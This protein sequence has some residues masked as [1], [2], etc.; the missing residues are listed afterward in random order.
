MSVFEG[1]KASKTINGSVILEDLT[2]TIS[3]GERVAI[4]GENGSGKSTLLKLIAGIYENTSGEVK[5]AHLEKGYVPEHFPETIKL[6]LQE[7]LMLVGKMSGKSKEELTS[8]ISEYAKLFNVTEFLHTPL[9][10]CSKGTKQKAGIIQA[11]L[12]EPDVLLMDEPLTGLDD[13]AQTELLTQLQSLQKNQ[14]VIFTAHESYLIDAFAERVL[15]IKSGRLVYD[16]TKLNQE[17]VRIIKATVPTRE[18]ISGIQ[19]MSKKWHGESLVE[20]TVSANESDR[21]L[22]LLLKQG[23]SIIEVSEKR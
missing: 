20:L 14:T 22:T 9:K 15:Q 2:L 3:Q 12:K 8:E 11:L 7:Y 4:T 1:N 19:A 13:K 17:K 16:S 23:C 18:Y 21:V 10:N 6:K 5:R